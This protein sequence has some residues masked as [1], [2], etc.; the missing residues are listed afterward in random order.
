MIKHTILYA[1]ND[2]DDYFLLKTAFD[3]VR[4]DVDLVHVD[5]GWEVLEH[6]QKILLPSL[7]PSLIILDINMNGIGGKETVKLLKGTKRY[8]DIPLVMFTSSRSEVD[9]SFCREHNIEMVSKPSGFDKLVEKAKYFGELCDKA[10]ENKF[11]PH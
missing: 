1:E 7:Y 6:L 4:H 5:D 10:I 9:A 2:F 3:Y 11:K 8:N